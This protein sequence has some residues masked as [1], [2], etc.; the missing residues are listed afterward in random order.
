MFLK[1]IRIVKEIACIYQNLICSW[2]TDKINEFS[3]MFFFEVKIKQFR[4]QV[5]N[6]GKIATISIKILSRKWK[7]FTMLIDWRCLCRIKVRSYLLSVICASIIDWKI[8]S[9]YLIAINVS[10]TAFVITIIIFYGRSCAKFC[11]K[12]LSHIQ[13]VCYR[14]KIIVIQK[15]KIRRVV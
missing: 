12:P 13:L 1:S 10:C 7:Q 2:V 3:G 6:I 8:V 15:S 4:P 9:H 5:G 11:S 14:Q